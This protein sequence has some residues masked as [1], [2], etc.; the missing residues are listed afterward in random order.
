MMRLGSTAAV[1]EARHHATDRWRGEQRGNPMKYSS[2]SAVGA[3]TVLSLAGAGI[4]A[5][6]AVTLT[7]ASSASAAVV[8]PES[9]G[10]T[11]PGSSTRLQHHRGRPEVREHPQLVVVGVES[12]S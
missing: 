1:A 12:A 10:F 11:G 2:L 7:G 9:G 3:A 8:V 6:S 4:A 5:S